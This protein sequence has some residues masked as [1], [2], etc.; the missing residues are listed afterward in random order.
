[1]VRPVSGSF[2]NSRPRRLRRDE[3]SRRLVRE[4]RLSTDDLIW[5]G[6][7]VEGQGQREA[8]PPTPDPDATAVDGRAVEQQERQ[9]GQQE[10]H[11]VDGEQ[12]G[13]PMP[14]P[15]RD[16]SRHQEGQHDDQGVGQV[17]EHVR[18]GLELDR[19]GGLGAPDGGEELPRTL[20][21][22]FGPPVLLGLEGSHSIGKLGGHHDVDEVAERP[23]RELR[24]VREVHVLGQ[25]VVGP[26]TGVGDGLAAPD[27]R[28]AVKIEIQQTYPLSEA[29]RAHQDLEARK[30]TGSTVLLP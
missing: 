21:R 23:S 29:A 25:G 18:R 15:C 19:Q 3:F 16:R 1:M 24:A 12:H 5:P 22:A 8:Y 17:G 30:T 6:F 14:H 26:T 11:Q 2:P 10:Q 28:G 4:S 13:A 20:E 7:V 9:H 27:P